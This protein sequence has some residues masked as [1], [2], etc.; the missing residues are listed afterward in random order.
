MAQATATSPAAGR[1]PLEF[2]IDRIW[3]FFCSVRAAV[4]EIA[5][6]AILTLLGTLR[7][8]SVPNSIQEALPFLKPVT[9]RWYAYDFFHSFP[10]VFMLALLSVAIAIC[11][12]NRAPSIWRTI[13]NPTVSTTQGF[14][15]GADASASF[16][17]AQAPA[18]MAATIAA[19]LRSKR[20]RVL[21]ETRGDEIHLYGDRNRYAKLGTFPFHLALI[22][23]LVGGIV[24]ARYGFRENQFTIPEQ[25]IRQ[26]GHGTGLSVK[27]EQFNDSYREN[28]VP[29]DYRS[30]LV[31]YKNGKEVKRGSIRVNHPMTY[32]TVVFYQSGFGQA[33]SLKVTDATGVA[34]F[35]DSIPLGE[36][37]S[38]TN[39]NA[40]AGIQDLPQ[41]GYRLNVIAPNEA[42][43]GR[44]EIGDVKLNSGEMYVQIVPIG[45][46]AA[47][48]EVQGAIVGQGDTVTLGGIA[49]QFLRERRFTS[50]QVA[51]NP[52]IPIFWAAAV[53]LVGGLAVT[54]YF[55]H[56]RIRAIVASNAGAAGGSLAKLAP[57]AKRDWSGQRDF[58]RC[59]DALEACLAIRPVVK[60]RPDYPTL[61]ESAA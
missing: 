45:P 37:H 58:F 54:F 46:N 31:V 33:V 20:Y 12:L 21:T 49:V 47:T 51:R 7:G 55:P 48:Q 40:P 4:Y 32:G 44:P 18:E 43:D 9:D 17:G 56:R 52:G 57:L 34:I 30:D 36:Y 15:N 19:T 24:G 53:L 60:G 61:Q 16:A 23:I 10:F 38:T 5:I 14:L 11:T 8:S 59:V 41:V 2:V 27:L 26:V 13:T 22:M 25:S 42:L 6:L 1:S 39:P 35:D 29:E 50:L 3:R 28:A